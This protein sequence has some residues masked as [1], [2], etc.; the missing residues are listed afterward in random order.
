M[1]YTYGSIGTC[2]LGGGATSSYYQARLGYQVN[3][4]SIENNT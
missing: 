1:A 2:K 4:Q 3:S